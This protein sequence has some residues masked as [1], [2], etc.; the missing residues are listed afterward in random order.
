M[1]RRGDAPDSSSLT[2]A[3]MDARA[4]D[5]PLV[6]VITGAS[7]GIGRETAR[8]YART[9]AR[10]VLA[11]RS[12]PGLETVAQ[13]CRAR[14]AD[15]LVVPTDVS[16]E[17]AVVGLVSAAIAAHGRI[18]VWVGNAGVSAYGRFEDLPSDVFRQV[19]ETNLMGQVHGARA[20]L[21]HFRRQGAGV[22]V[23]VGSLYS[24]VGSPM[25]SPYVTSKFGLLGFA[26][27]LRQELRGTPVS[28]HV[29]LPSTIDTPVYQRAAN[30]TGRRIHPLPPVAAP[31]RVARAIVRAPHRRRPVIYVGRIQ[32][33]VL[34]V[35]DFAPRIYDAAASWLMDH[36]ELRGHLPERS[37]GTVMAPSDSAGPVTGEWGGTGARKVRRSPIPDVSRAAARCAQTCRNSLSDVTP[38]DQVE[39]CRAGALTCDS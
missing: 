29:V 15:V 16:D 28:V 8:T 21:P 9:R 22:L 4:D 5:S 33:A 30:V 6:V 12:R 32:M 25:I 11:S 17:R 10:L 14:G 20:V 35:H 34:P 27:S 18:D 39:R 23:L 26:E 1:A 19:V 36:V 38:S 3:T 2:T 24:R 37:T 31:K 7:S 13:E